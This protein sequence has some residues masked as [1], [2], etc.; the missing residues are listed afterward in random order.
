V[1]KLNR[2][3]YRCSPKRVLCGISVGAWVT[4]D[5]EEAVFSKVEEALVLIRTYAP[6]RFARLQQDVGCIFVFGSL[7]YRGTWRNEIRMCELKETFIRSPETS[8]ATV[9]SVLVHEAM[10]ARLMRWG[11]G[12]EEYR[13]ARTERI[14]YKAQRAFARR[15][16]DGEGLVGEAGQR[17]DETRDHALWSDAAFRERN[18]Q[19]LR[20]M[21]WPEWTLR[22]LAGLAA[23]L[24]ARRRAA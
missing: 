8:A 4:K 1:S 12:Y 9:A 24:Q 17:I 13:R 2:F 5:E 6:L 3:F 22:A 23:R 10:H 19:T 11:F 7:D 20:D 15:L 14:C 16:P 18:L 21:G